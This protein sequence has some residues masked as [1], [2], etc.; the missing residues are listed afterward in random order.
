[1][2]QAQD[3]YRVNPAPQKETE[4]I[5]ATVE[6]SEGELAVGGDVLEVKT[7]DRKNAARLVPSPTTWIHTKTMQKWTPPE[8]GNSSRQIVSATFASGRHSIRSAAL[9]FA[10]APNAKVCTIA[11]YT[12]RSRPKIT[13]KT[14]QYRLPPTMSASGS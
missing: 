1:M 12:T 3:W 13:G 10:G 4:K 8:G 14:I 11:P 7:N 9:P 6:V 2:T 5:H